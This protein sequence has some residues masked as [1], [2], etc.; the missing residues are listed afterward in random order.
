MFSAPFSERLALHDY[1]E[2][3]FDASKTITLDEVLHEEQV[4]F[5]KKD[6]NFTL[7]EFPLVVWSKVYFSNESD[8]DVIAALTFCHLADSIELYLTTDGVV[9]H[10]GRTGTA[11]DP[12]KKPMPSVN[13]HLQLSLSANTVQVLYLRQFFLTPVTEEHVG[14]LF[15]RDPA[16]IVGELTLN[17]GFQAFYAG[18][19][20]MFAMLSFFG[21]RLLRDRSFVYFSLVHLTFTFYFLVVYNVFGLLI[22]S[23]SFTSEV[24]I[25]SISISFLIL[26]LFLFISHYLQLAKWSPLYYRAVLIVSVFVALN[27]YFHPLFIDS[28]LLSVTV[29]NIFILIWVVAIVLPI[30]RLARKGHMAAKNLLASIAI[31][32]MASVVYILSILGFIPISLFTKYS[33]QIA[34]VLFSLLVFYQ[35]F[36]AVRKLE[37]EK[38]RALTMND[39]KSR[40]FT[41]LSHEFRTPLT[42]ILAP[43]DRLLDTAT[44]DEEV[45]LIKLVKKHANRLL[46]MV[47]Q[48]LDIAKIEGN[49]VKLSVAEVDVVPYVKGI[50]M[51]FES[52]AEMR[53]IELRFVT[54]LQSAPL[55][56]DAEKME[57]ILYN[58]FSNA[59]KNT[60]AGGV[61]T[62]EV[63][64]IDEKVLI[65]VRDT[66]SGIPAELLPFIFDRFFR[67]ESTETDGNGIGL[68]L[69]KELTELHHGTLSVESAEGVGSTFTV[70]LTK[71]NAHFKTNVLR[72]G[73]VA[74]GSSTI[75]T[76][77]DLTLLE[78]DVEG[79]GFGAE[80]PDVHIGSKPVILLVEDNTDVRSFI[81]SQLT[82]QFDIVEADNGQSGFDLALEQAPELVISDVMMPEM[83]GVELCKL[84][85]SDVRTSHI[86]VIL[87]T[88]KTEQEHRLE[89]LEAGADDYLH[90]PFFA[91]ELNVRVRK[92]IELRVQLRKRLL[93][94]PTLSFRSIEGNPVEQNFIEQ[95]STF[96]DEHLANPQFNVALLADSV[97][98]SV[99]QLNRKLRSITGMTA[100][101]FVQHIRLKK[102]LILLE[103]QDM[104]VSEV[105]HVTG[106]SSTAYFIKSFREHYGKTPGSVL[107]QD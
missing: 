4:S 6:D 74:N 21:W 71:G 27:K 104:N 100:N 82:D 34:S 7:P 12:L 106:F 95:I 101:K 1:V 88:A 79:D 105:A 9:K 33:I 40:F 64:N 41:N 47:N 103:T 58:L 25:Q 62:V 65:H 96:I 70:A 16:L 68:C 75:N 63:V 14:E 89:G 50:L 93:E 80:A 8:Q 43:A 39:V 46:N 61:I 32:A 97:K 66:G 23:H 57:V 37:N 87:L 48:L 78:S 19:M 56:L 54:S 18:L 53:Q 73:Q 86:P 29:H 51:S 2:I 90:K 77:A 36:V 26:S 11:Y 69:A 49:D 35:L 22:S 76:Q 13:N 60:S 17:Y 38:Q 67:V 44:N 81:H 42:L 3:W 15:I 85:K 10:A 98:L 102:A 94:S 28:E 83:N 30:V 45:K 107:R 24:M 92:L 52:I 99:A 72:A 20:F 55:W 84:L 5:E 91:K 31:L 59:L